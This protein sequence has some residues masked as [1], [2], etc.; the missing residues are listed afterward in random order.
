MEDSLPKHG[1]PSSTIHRSFEQFE[2]VDLAFHL[3]IVP[4]HGASMS[5]CLR[6][7]GQPVYKTDK[8]CNATRLD[9]GFLVF[10]SL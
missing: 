7:I 8:L 10:S 9:V 2:F 1:K 4:G 5:N 6:I 3:T